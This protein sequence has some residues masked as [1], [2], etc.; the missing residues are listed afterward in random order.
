MERSVKVVYSEE[1]TAL[2]L[3]MRLLCEA[4]HSC[5]ADTAEASEPAEAA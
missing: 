4:V 1:S 3:L 5:C 2:S